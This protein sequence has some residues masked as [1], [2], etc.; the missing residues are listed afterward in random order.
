MTY[1]VIETGGKQYLIKAG[2]KLKIEKLAGERPLANVEFDKVLLAFDEKETKIGS[3][4]LEKTKV[5]GEWLG[6]KLAKK[7]IVFKYHSKTRY[8][9]KK[10]HRQPFSEVLIKEIKY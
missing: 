8:Q 2:D 6:D 1:A 10:G 3:P 4:H 7:V 9:K 5:I